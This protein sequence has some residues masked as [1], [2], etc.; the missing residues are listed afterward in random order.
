MLYGKLERDLQANRFEYFAQFFKGYMGVMPV[1]TA[2]LAPVITLLRT[3]PVF[4]VQRKE[5]AVYSGLFGFLLVAYVFYGRDFFMR[6]MLSSRKWTFAGAYMFLLPLILIMGSAVFFFEY[7]AELDTTVFR[8]THDSTDRTSVLAAA[9]IKYPLEHGVR[10]E[11]LYLGIFAAAEM[12]FV[13]MALKEDALDVAGVSE[14]DQ[15]F[16]G[17]G[18]A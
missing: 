9:G 2:A 11:M 12:A 15:L 16:L 1:L 10:L 14:R 8:H 17:E 4:E 18:N 7:N 3:V 5:L 6:S 13:F